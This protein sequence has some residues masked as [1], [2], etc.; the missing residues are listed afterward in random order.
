MMRQLPFK[1]N[2]QNEIY[3]RVIDDFC[4]VDLN[5]WKEKYPQYP[6]YDMEFSEV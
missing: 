1:Y 6:I 4:L 3:K 2:S 5:E